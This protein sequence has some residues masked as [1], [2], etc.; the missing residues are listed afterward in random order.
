[1][2]STQKGGTCSKYDIIVVP[3]QETENFIIILKMG[4]CISPLRAGRKTFVQLIGQTDVVKR[5]KRFEAKIKQVGKL[6]YIPY[7]Q[8]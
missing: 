8:D 1:M 5:Q 3:I 2:V 7:P 6:Q 4:N